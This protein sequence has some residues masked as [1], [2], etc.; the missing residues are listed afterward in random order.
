MF[1]SVHACV[2]VHV[3]VRV[4]ELKSNKK[5]KE[6]GVTIKLFF[7]ASLRVYMLLRLCKMCSMGPQCLTQFSN[8]SPI[9]SAYFLRMYVAIFA[10]S[11]CVGILPSQ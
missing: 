8:I 6:R 1:V 4:C 11:T 9:Y 5:R 2:S 10:R 3:P 7:D